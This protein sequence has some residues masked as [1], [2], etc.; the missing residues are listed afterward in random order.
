[1]L[2]DGGCLEVPS[3]VIQIIGFFIIKDTEGFHRNIQPSGIIEFL[4]ILHELCYREGC[5]L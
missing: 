2:E 4:Q 3:F 1:M 5:V